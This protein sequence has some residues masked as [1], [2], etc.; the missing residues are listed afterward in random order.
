MQYAEYTHEAFRNLSPKGMTV[1]I[2]M[3]AVEAHGP[4][5]PLDTDNILAERYSKLLAER[6]NAL[7]LPVIPYGQVWSLKDFPGSLTVSN[8]TLI[9]LLVELAVSLYDQGFRSVVFFSAHLGNM[10]AMKDASRVLYEQKPM[11]K[12]LYLFYP[13]LQKYAS[14]IREG[15]KGH[16]TYIHADEIETSLMLY[17][18]PE[19]VDMNKAIDD[20]PN[21]PV[22]ADYTPTP[23]HTFTKTAVLGEAKLATKEKGQY[24]VEKTL[25]DAVA[26]VQRMKEDL[27]D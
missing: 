16:H 8:Q 11:M 18:A 15:T 3:G 27:N 6:T 22:S 5:L 2:P 7:V 24:L 9:Q 17:L 19:C 26:L 12:S 23:W 1:I 20:P 14:E 21:I 25:T 4:H 13:N 10:N